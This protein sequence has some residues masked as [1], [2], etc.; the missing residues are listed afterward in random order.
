MQKY[1][2]NLNRSTNWLTIMYYR[3]V[4]Q[5]SALLLVIL[6]LWVE[7]NIINFVLMAFMIYLLKLHT[8]MMQPI[9]EYDMK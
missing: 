1:F 3:K 5:L 8:Q 9:K 6:L 7:F 4:F 2:P